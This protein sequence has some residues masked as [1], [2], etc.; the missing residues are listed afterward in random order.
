ME[1][2]SKEGTLGV[3]LEG[4]KVV[5][6][7]EMIRIE[8]ESVQNGGS[9]EG[10]M[11]MVGKKVAEHVE[12]F[13][14]NRGLAKRVT[15]L[16]GKGNNGGDALAAGTLLVKRGY[17][18]VGF[19]VVDVENSGPL[20]RK[21]VEAFLNAGGQIVRGV[22]PDLKGVLIDGLLGTGFRG[23]LA[24]SFEAIITRAN[25]SRLP[26]L[27]IDL[28]SGVNGET[29]EVDRSAI[30]ATETLFLGAAKL[31]CLTG[32][33]F[34]Y[35]GRL[36]SIDF[37]LP[38]HFLQGGRGKG[39]LIKEEVLPLLLPPIVKTRHKYEAGYVLALAGSPGMS[40]AAILA[41]SAALR[42]GAGIV[43]LFHPIEMDGEW[44]QAPVELIRTSDSFEDPALF[45][46]EA[47]RAKGCLIGPGLGK[48]NNLT[49]FV[50]TVAGSLRIPMVLD[51]DAFFHMKRFPKGALLTPHGG[52]M[53]CLLGKKSFSLADCQGFCETHGV[54]VLLKGAPT[55]IFHPKTLPLVSLRGDPGM[56]TAGAGDVLTGIVAAFLAQGLKGREAAALG[57]HLHGLCGEI[58]AAEKTSYALIASDLITALPKSFDRL[59]HFSN[60]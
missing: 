4:D 41:C 8:R 9:E 16:V 28:P 24:P 7:S 53:G 57:A 26:I 56:A 42:A 21:Q 59:L 6:A 52:E 32:K 55:W 14:Q 46:E 1:L 3:V 13:I 12:G 11:Q 51:A 10:Y 38:L 48:G 23:G 20:C 15:L 49:R 27:A 22:I 47:N 45:L 18:V 39:H 30:R 43:R 60:V 40:G 17:Q 37:G 25:Q 44:S 2:Q 35:V 54:T 50:Q 58:S 36:V 33:G 29:G 5:E 31:G 34:G 19:H